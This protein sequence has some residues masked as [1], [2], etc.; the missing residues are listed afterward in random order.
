MSIS[1]SITSSF[2]CDGGSNFYGNYYTGQ[3]V[4][5]SMNSPALNFYRLRLR[6]SIITIDS[7]D[8]TSKVK[9]LFTA[10]LTQ[11]L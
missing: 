2:N 3:I 1:P 10:G 7:W 6:F 4:T 5:V 8:I 9:I 11:S